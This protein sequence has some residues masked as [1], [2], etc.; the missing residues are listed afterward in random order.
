MRKGKQ[1]MDNYWD[2]E[3]VIGEVMKGEHTKF[4]MK[5]CSRNGKQYLVI[6]DHYNS[7]NDPEWKFGK[8]GITIPL[9]D[10][11]VLG[12]LVGVIETNFQETLGAFAAI[13]TGGQV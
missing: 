3:E 13:E 6:W 4:V 8:H 5:R 7:T 2:K 9:S 10:P 1:K 11:G 12:S